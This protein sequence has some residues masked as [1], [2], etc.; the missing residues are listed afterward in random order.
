M[1]YH[2]DRLVEGQ[3]VH[4]LRQ[5]MND[6][7]FYEKGVGLAHMQVSYRSVMDLSEGSNHCC[8]PLKATYERAAENYF[9]K[10]GE[11]GVGDRVEKCLTKQKHRLMWER[12]HGPV[13]TGM[14]EDAVEAE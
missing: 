6:C 12:R 3:I 9:I 4:L 11:L 14:K 13:G 1:Q 7:I 10:Y 8:A 5:R 2:R